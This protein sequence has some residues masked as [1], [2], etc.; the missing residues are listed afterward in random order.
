[1]GDAPGAGGTARAPG[2]GVI[3][4]AARW[5]ALADQAAFEEASGAS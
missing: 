3:A 1:M 4:A 2:T 5:Y